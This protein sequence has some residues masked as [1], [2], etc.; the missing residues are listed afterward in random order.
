MSPPRSLLLAL[1]YATG[2]LCAPAAQASATCTELD[3]ESGALLETFL[4]DA[5][6][7]ETASAGAR[8][9]R[10]VYLVSAFADASAVAVTVRDAAGRVVGRASLDDAGAACVSGV[11]TGAGIE[12]DADSIIGI[13][14]EVGVTVRLDEWTPVIPPDAS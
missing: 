4:T 8:L 13:T 12:V 7:G 9:G 5:G 10:R 6:A 11:V 14:I 3:A 2:L 1:L